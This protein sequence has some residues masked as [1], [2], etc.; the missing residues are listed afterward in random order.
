MSGGPPKSLGSERA[1]SWS[2]GVQ[3]EKKFLKKRWA[4]EPFQDTRR[5]DYSS[6][7]R[8]SGR[9][10]RD[11]KKALPFRN[12]LGVVLSRSAGE[13]PTLGRP[14]QKARDRRTSSSLMAKEVSSGRITRGRWGKF[15][16]HR[17]KAPKARVCFGLGK[18]GSRESSRYMTA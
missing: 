7:A 11:D 8:E 18:K 5:G 4:R 6:K 3:E 12:R 15:Y 13:K 14:S 17:K 1:E 10:V 2:S 9:T 16:S